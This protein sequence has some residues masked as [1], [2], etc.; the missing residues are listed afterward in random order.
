MH[1]IHSTISYVFWGWH[2]EP[3]LPSDLY[4]VKAILAS[5]ASKGIVPKFLTSVY[6]WVDQAIVVALQ[7][8]NYKQTDGSDTRVI[9]ATE[10]Y[11]GT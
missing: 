7:Q 6:L 1:D 3:S 9:Q 11:K 2:L 10:N 5:H 8:E 4:L